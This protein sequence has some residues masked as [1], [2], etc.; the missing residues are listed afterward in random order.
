LV[1]KIRGIDKDSAGVSKQ[2]RI[3]EREEDTRTNILQQH[4][5]HNTP[6]AAN[7]ENNM[8]DENENTPM[9]ENTP[10]A[11]LLPSNYDIHPSHPASPFQNESSPFQLASAG[12]DGELIPEEELGPERDAFTMLKGI[13]SGSIDAKEIK[14]GERRIV[15]DMLRKQGRGQDQIAAMLEV[16]RRTIVSDYAWLKER[17]VDKVR[18]IDAYELGGE[19]FEMGFAAVE[20]ALTDGKP[21]M[22]AQ[23]L[24]DITE[25]LQSLGIVYRAPATSKVAALVAHTGVQQGFG[26]YMDQVADEKEKVVAVLGKMMGALKGSSAE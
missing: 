9:Q 7:E 2:A 1:R 24:R 22:V 15:V 18:H 16:S 12:S 5:S 11:H 23:V 3:V 25:M 6:T 8:S 4:V 26:N 20:R 17:A 13:Q 14:Q 10:V 19:I 21:R